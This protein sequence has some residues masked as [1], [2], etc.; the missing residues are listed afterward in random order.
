MQY[1]LHL[2]QGLYAQTSPNPSVGAVLIKDG[3]VIGAGAHLKAGEPHAEIHALRMAGDKARDAVMYVTLEPCVHH[4]KT[5]PCTEAIIAAGVKKVVVGSRDPNPRVYG[6]GIE[7]LREAGI[8]VVEGVE[9]MA[10]AWTNRFFF[11]RMRLGRP[12]VTIKM[13]MTL[14]GK[15]ATKTGDSRWVSGEISRRY[16]HTLRRTYD[17]IMVGSGT[18]SVDDP[19]LTARLDRPEVGQAVGRQP[20]RIVVDSKL[21]L[22]PMLRL[23]QDRSAKTL[24][25][26]R[27]DAAAQTIDTLRRLGID[28]MTVPSRGRASQ[29]EE[30]EA[31][32][33]SMDLAVDLKEALKLLADRGIQSLFVE[34]GGTLN[35]ALLQEG[36]VDEYVLFIA[37]KVIGGVSAKTPVEGE[38]LLRME[39][40]YPFEII[41][42]ERLGEDILVRALAKRTDGQ[43]AYDPN[44]T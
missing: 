34:G 17:A 35:A 9:Q 39:D 20:L 37:P 8:T 31:D 12:Y 36:L 23:F 43:L 41:A 22:S 6:R 24:V 4:G 15:I 10:V 7:R 28:I 18:A 29:V 5:P 14:D 11:T 2:S 13:A 40:A 30:V 3:E 33:R 21:R 42:V 1:A 44:Y 32:G 27:D 16:V 38:G 25:M 19:L 26:T